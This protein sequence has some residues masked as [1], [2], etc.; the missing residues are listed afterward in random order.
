MPENIPDVDPSA[1][2]DE[3]PHERFEAS[4][5]GLVQWCAVGVRANGVVAVG[6]FASIQQQCGDL[7][8]TEL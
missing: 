4:P 8:V 6:V 7:Y 5:C 1:S 2:R 3:E